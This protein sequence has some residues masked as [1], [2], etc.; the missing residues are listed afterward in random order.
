MRIKRKIKIAFYEVFGD[1]IFDFKAKQRLRIRAKR[2]LRQHKPVAAFRELESSLKGVSYPDNNFNKIMSMV[3]SDLELF[4]HITQRFRYDRG[5]LHHVSHD[6]EFLHFLAPARKS[7]PAHPYERENARAIRIDVESLF[8][9]GT[10]MIQRSLLLLKM[11]LPDKSSN[12]KIDDMYS[13]IGRFYYELSRSTQLSDISRRFRDQFLIR[14]KWIYAALR[15]YR[16]EFIE[17]LD[18]GYQQGMNYGLYTNDFSL[19][20]YK[21]NYNDSDNLKIEKFRTKLEGK[22][23]RIPG[24][25]NGDR[26]LINRYYVQMLFD[27][28]AV[29]P[30]EVLSEALS[31]IEDIGVHS[32]QPEK[33]IS[34]LDAYMEGVFNFMKQELDH[35]ELAKYIEST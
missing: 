10:I 35:S 31:L 24:R 27:N 3:L 23:I 6:D 25:S 33:V 28:I 30:D 21:W 34:E 22:G 7:Y 9:F 12:P 8:I 32:P 16:N 19:S 13:K 2:N 20:S 17:H 15:F 26:D 4:Q 11:Y 18:K 5:I 29:V 1:L 14:L